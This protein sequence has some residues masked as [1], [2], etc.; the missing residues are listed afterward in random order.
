MKTDKNYL[1]AFYISN[2]GPKETDWFEISVLMTEV[3][4]LSHQKLLAFPS[5]YRFYQNLSD[6]MQICKPT[7]R[8]K[9]ESNENYTKYFIAFYNIKR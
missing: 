8:T 3:S 6:H 7:K 9:Q 4:G 1:P 5:L 2:P